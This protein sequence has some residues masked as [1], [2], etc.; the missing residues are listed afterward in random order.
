MAKTTTRVNSYDAE[1]AAIA[2]R[3]KK[4]E[5]QLSGGQELKI[6]NGRLYFMGAEVPGGKLECIILHNIPVNLYYDPRVKYDAKNPVPPICYALG[7]DLDDPL[8][9]M[10]PHEK[11]SDPQHHAC[12]GCPMNEFGTANTGRGKACQNTRRVAVLPLDVLDDPSTIAGASV[13]YLKV[14]ATNGKGL[15]GFVK[16]VEEVYKKPTFAVVA[17]ITVTPDPDT[18]HHISFEFVEEIKDTKAIQALLAKYKTELE[19]IAWTYQERAEEAPAKGRG[20]RQTP[21]GSKY[22]PA[23]VK[24]RG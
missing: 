5:D 22:A 17:K 16:Q 10:C 23:P 11:S 7:T 12:K 21:K 6:N 18:Q 15:S 4:I 9:T 8:G 20:A 14:S 24:K 13:A 3:S 2:A 1:L 19:A